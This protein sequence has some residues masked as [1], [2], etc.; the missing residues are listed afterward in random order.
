MN[1]IPPDSLLSIQWPTPGSQISIFRFFD[2]LVG[3]IFLIVAAILLNAALACVFISKTALM[4]V[5]KAKFCISA[6]VTNQRNCKDY[7][8][9]MD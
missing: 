3:G 5:Y 6:A 4:L 2:Y 8:D 7:R 9:M 1:K